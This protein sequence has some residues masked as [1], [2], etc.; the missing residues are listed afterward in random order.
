MRQCFKLIFEQWKSVLT[1]DCRHLILGSLK[2]NRFSETIFHFL[3]IR[4]HEDLKPNTTGYLG[5]KFALLLFL[6]SN[7][8]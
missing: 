2:M 4:F 6:F 3:K 7:E 8:K 1:G 5:S